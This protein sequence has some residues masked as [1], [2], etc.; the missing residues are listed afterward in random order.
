MSASSEKAESLEIGEVNLW[1]LYR[2]EDEGG[3]IGTPICLFRFKEDAE[4]WLDEH[5]EDYPDTVIIAVV[6]RLA[7]YNHYKYFE[8]FPP[9]TVLDTKE[10]I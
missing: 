3:N 4:K 5:M 1:G 10:E 6:A 8:V 2:S 9:E 7:G